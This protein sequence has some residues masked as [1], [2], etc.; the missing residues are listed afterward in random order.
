[1]LSLHVALPI[2][3]I[4]AWNGW[5]ALCRRYRL[6]RSGSFIIRD[7]A[8]IRA[9]LSSISHMDD[10]IGAESSMDERGTH[11]DHLAL[12]V[13]SASQETQS[14]GYPPNPFAAHQP[15]IRTDRDRQSVV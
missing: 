15:L 5:G 6:V 4:H 11:Q 9:A 7:G 1:M 12:I 13:Y 2:Y 3:G 10:A 14:S 8:H